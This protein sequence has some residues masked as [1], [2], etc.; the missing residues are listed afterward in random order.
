MWYTQEL[1]LENGGW[2]TDHRCLHESVPQLICVWLGVSKGLLD[3][4][5]SWPRI[6]AGGEIHW[7]PISLRPP[8][9]KRSPASFREDAAQ[10]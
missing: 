6:E 2:M 8:G 10:V 7:F 3:A 1:T 9:Y 4:S 5:K